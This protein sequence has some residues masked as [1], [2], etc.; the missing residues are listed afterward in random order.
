MFFAFKLL[1]YLVTNYKTKITII[2]NKKIKNSLKKKNLFMI[3]KLF[4][5]FFFLSFH[6]KPIKLREKKN[7]Y[8]FDKFF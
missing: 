2:E 7:S 6:A 5:S 8:I 4:H 1:Y 3:A